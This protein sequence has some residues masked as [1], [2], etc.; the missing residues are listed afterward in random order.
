MSA[1]GCAIDLDSSRIQ[2]IQETSTPTLASEV[3]QE[4]EKVRDIL[5]DQNTEPLAKAFSENEEDI[6]QYF[7]QHRSTYY[8]TTHRA[9][10]HKPI[11][12]SKDG[13]DVELEDQSIWQVHSWDAS[14]VKKWK[15][16]H[17]IVIAPN[18]NIFTKGSYPYKLINLDTGHIA[19]AYMKF[20]PVFN[21]P[22]IDIYVHWIDEIDY[23]NRLIRLD[24]GSVW[25]IAWADGNVMK[26]FDRY[27]I[28][29]IGTNDGWYKGSYPNILICVKNSA[30]IRGA[31]IH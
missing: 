19:K 23:F 6:E 31:V 24:D 2:C 25:S 13:R 12:T 9:S 8:S 4:D 22:N 17:T 30:Y 16:F 29:I 27:N 18:K 10:F 28:V 1:N 11:N 14:K 20:T 26:H 5:D 7:D 15:S 3:L 21:D